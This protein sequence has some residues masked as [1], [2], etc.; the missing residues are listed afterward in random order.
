MNR[1]RRVAMSCGFACRVTIRGFIVVSCAVSAVNPQVVPRRE[2]SATEDALTMITDVRILSW[3]ADQNRIV[4]V[5]GFLPP[6]IEDGLL[7]GVVRMKRRY[8]A[9]RRIV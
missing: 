5:P 9:A 8:Q 4:A 2:R 3:V 6:A 7:P 1:T